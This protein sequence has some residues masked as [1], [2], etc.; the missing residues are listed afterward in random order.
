MVERKPQMD[1]VSEYVSGRKVVNGDEYTIE[2]IALKTSFS[3]GSRQ[4]PD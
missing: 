3:P 1:E 2:M 4:K